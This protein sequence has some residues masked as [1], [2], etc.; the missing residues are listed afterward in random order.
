MAISMYV[1]ILIGLVAAIL[2]AL[3]G[4]AWYASARLPVPSAPANVAMQ[5]PYVPGLSPPI[6]MKGK[7]EKLGA[8]AGSVEVFLS[9]V[10]TSA[11]LNKN[12]ARLSMYAAGF[13]AIAL[14]LPR[15]NEVIVLLGFW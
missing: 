3:S 9:V 4:K 8:L 13:S 2:S 15:I 1:S 12:T 14:M 11:D 10:R 6:S 5:G 7:V